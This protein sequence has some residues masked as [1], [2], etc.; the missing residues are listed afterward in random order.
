MASLPS[1][2]GSSNSWGATLNSY[3]LV[4]HNA[5]G[6]LIALPPNWTNPLSEVY[7]AVGNGTTDDTTAINAALAATPQGGTCF[8]PGG[9]TYKISGTLTVPQLVTFLGAETPDPTAG[10]IISVANGANLSAVISDSTF[11]S[12]GTFVST[13]P[14][15]QGIVINANGANQSSGTGVGIAMC[16]YRGEVIN[17]RVNS[18]RGDGIRISNQSNNA[19]VVTGTPVECKIRDNTIAGCGTGNLANNREGIA[20]RDSGSSSVTDF[21]ITRNVIWAGALAETNGMGIYANSASGGLISENHLYGI[22]THGLYITGGGSTRI[23]NNYVEYFGQLASFGACYAIYAMDSGGAPGTHISGN[24]VNFDDTVTGNTFVGLYLINVGSNDQA[25]FS[26]G[27]NMFYTTAVPGATAISIQNQG[28]ATNFTVA[29]CPQMVSGFTNPYVL[30]NQYGTYIGTMF[31]TIQSPAYASTLAVDLTKGTVVGVTLDGNVTM[32]V[33]TQMTA[34]MR[35][36][37]IFYQDATGGRTVTWS[38]NNTGFSK[39]QNANFV[40]TITANAMSAVSFVTDG[41]DM[42]QVA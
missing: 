38:N 39:W 2:G 10:S 24:T 34:G 7:G 4:A 28:A 36:T 37:F 40:P 30:L 33:P 21:W 27:P 8:L 22:G 17:C 5:D 12:N 15:V 41:Y 35:F 14:R 11:S 3:L 42:I 6:T 23:I 16:S 25:F 26:L 19:S 13:G 31:D 1:P 32:D 18:T 20:M 9:H 29:G